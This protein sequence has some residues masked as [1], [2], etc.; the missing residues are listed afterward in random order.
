MSF[1][2]SSKTIQDRVSAADRD[3]IWLQCESRR[4]IGRTHKGPFKILKWKKKEDKKHQSGDF[5][6]RGV[7]EGERDGVATWAYPMDLSTGEYVIL[8]PP[9]RGCLPMGPGQN[10][11][12]LSFKVDLAG[13]FY[14]RQLLDSYNWV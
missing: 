1:E 5:V 12:A 8:L 13:D 6:L 9:A 7:R 14:T 11:F 2:E 3:G 4:V 10:T